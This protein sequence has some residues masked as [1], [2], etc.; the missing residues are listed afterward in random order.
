MICQ[1]IL[2]IS[3]KWASAKFKFDLKEQDVMLWLRVLESIPLQWKR[4]VKSHDMKLADDVSAGP[5]L[6]MAVKSAYNILLILVCKNMFHISEVNQN[7]SQQSK[8]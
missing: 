3:L 4:K 6:N 7:S 2:A 8:H 1:T 5:S